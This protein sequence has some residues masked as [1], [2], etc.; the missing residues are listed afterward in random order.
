MSYFNNVWKSLPSELKK[1][2]TILFILI[3]ISTCLEVL[4]IGLIVP[5]VL[6]FIEDDLVLKYPFL[7][8]VV[9]YFFF[10][11]NK[12]DY[13]KFGLIILLGVYFIKNSFLTF[14]AYYESK[15]VNEVKSSISN[16]LF[17]YYLCEELAFHNKMNSAHLINNLTKEIPI[18]SNAFMHMIIFITEIFVFSGIAILLLYYQPKGFLI[19]A[20]ISFVVIWTYNFFTSQKLD[21]LG[22]RRQV[23]DSL[24]VQKIQQG[25]VGLR[26]IKIYNRELGFFSSFK[27]SI[28]NVYNIAW[29]SDFIHK[30]PRLLLEF[31]SVLS[32]AAIVLLFI[33]FSF[34]T[35]DIIVI[36][37]LFALAAARMLPSLSRIY[38]AFQK[39]K[40]GN[41]ATQLISNELVKFDK[42]NQLNKISK[43]DISNTQST[44]KTK[45]D[46]NLSIKVENLSF[47]YYNNETKIFDKINFEIKKGQ[48]IGI[49]GPSGS[50]KSTLADI[51]LGLLSSTEG[52]VLVD[53]RDIFENL[54]SWQKKASYVPQSIFLTD[55][56]LS[57]NIALGIEDEKID[58]K[59]LEEAVLAVELD[60]FVNSLPSGLD[61]IVG[62]RGSRLSGG[63]K[64]RIGLAR[65]LYNNPRLLVLD[66]T[67]NSLDKETEKKIIET[68][69]KIKD[70]KTI[71][72]I[73]HDKEVLKNCDLVYTI[74]NKKVYKD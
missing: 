59:K 30:I 61:T 63:Q 53:N 42:K 5:V 51:L 10:E 3:L 22:K 70:D 40:F 27:K 56:K 20:I 43:I 48:L 34:E 4:G 66:E 23:N 14:F 60:G 49:K 21:D 57:R 16:K 25:L 41:A 13:I 50:G 26:E 29:L 33:N 15:F 12:I 2:S 47:S 31:A 18:F 52:K 44:L 45:S 7:H 6:F 35:N 72:F 68:I 73:S 28:L 58:K 1:K 65:A 32:L 39:I 37:G 36:L 64:Q 9:S 24:I 54:L 19:V 62:E 46:F 8:S 55:D 11:P 67:T 38:N 17:K 69:L 71:I 74:N